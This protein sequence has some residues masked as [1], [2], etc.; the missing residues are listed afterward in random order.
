MSYQD[1]NNTAWG[2][3]EVQVGAVNATDGGKMPTAGMALIGFVKEGSLDIEQQEGDTKEWKA[4][5]GEIVD[6]LTTASA[7]RIKF[8][9]KNL[10]KSVMEKV[11]DVKE[12]GDKLEVYNLT[13]SKEFAL[14]IVPAT[15]GAEVFSA[16]RVKLSGVMKLGDDVGYGI[17]V[18][19]T[20][21]KAKVDSPLFSLEK[22]KA[23]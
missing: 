20:I 10:N 8:H 7:L 3:L 18:T 22:K 4:V 6:T 5:G 14:S 12:V 17:D 2:K 13:S 11:F 21:L 19:A 16:P 15:I 9:V 1:T 23:L